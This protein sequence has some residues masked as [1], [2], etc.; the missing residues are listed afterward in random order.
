MGRCTCVPE[1]TFWLEEQYHND[2]TVDTTIV[3][4]SESK[5][6]LVSSLCVDGGHAPAID[7]D[8]E[9]Q[10]LKKKIIFPGI[11]VAGVTYRSVAGALARCGIISQGELTRIL[12]STIDIYWYRDMPFRVIVPT[13]VVL[14]KTDGHF[15][16]FFDIR[17]R[18]DHYSALLQALEEA[19]VVETDFIKMT[20]DKGMSLLYLHGRKPKTI[21]VPTK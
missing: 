20:E 18:W 12:A 10:F 14:S 2:Y 16:L 13:R 11:L 4:S 17:T 1:R 5:A 19:E 3:E 8:R 6:N 7:V 9:V 15:H 21:R